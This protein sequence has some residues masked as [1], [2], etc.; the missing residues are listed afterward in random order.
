MSLLLIL[1]GGA[2]AIAKTV[3]DSRNAKKKL[4]EDKRHNKTMEEIGRIGSG[5]YLR[6]NVKGG[7]GLFLKKQQSKNYH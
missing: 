3:I 6:K 4:E 5:L 7:L 1:V 2:S